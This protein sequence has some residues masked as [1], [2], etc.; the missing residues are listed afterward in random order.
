MGATRRLRPNKG[1][2]MRTLIPG[3][4]RDVQPICCA[5]DQSQAM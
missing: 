4:R 5:A 1:R 2:R 3:K